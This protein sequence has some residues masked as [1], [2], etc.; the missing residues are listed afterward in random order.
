M[1][2]PPLPYVTTFSEQFW[3]SYFFILFQSNLFDTTVT[4]LEQL[5]L[6][7]SCF[8]EELFFQNNHFFRSIYLFRIATFSERNSSE[9]PLFEKRKF[10]RA[11]TFPNSYL[12]GGEIVQNK[13]IYRRVTFSKRVLLHSM[14]V[15]RKATFWKK[16]T[17]QKSNIPHYLLFLESYVF[18]VATFSKDATFYGS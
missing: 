12:F 1:A 7:S 15:F 16:L 4:F 18:G 17:S 14:H 3:R 11:V 13:N 2:I 6:Q 10:F 5:S 8:F 9:Q